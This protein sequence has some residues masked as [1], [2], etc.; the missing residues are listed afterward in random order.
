MPSNSSDLA[1]ALVGG[2]RAF[3][4]YLSDRASGRAEWDLDLEIPLSVVGERHH[5]C[6]RWTAFDNTTGWLAVT[7]DDT[8]SEEFDYAGLARSIVAVVSTVADTF[9][10]SP[11]LRRTRT[12][13]QL[14][15]RNRWVVSVR[16]TKNSLVKGQAEALIGHLRSLCRSIPADPAAEALLGIGAGRVGRWDGSD[17]RIVASKIGEMILHA[18]DGGRCRGTTLLSYVCSDDVV[19]VDVSA[20]GAVE[21]ALPTSVGLSELKTL[22]ASAASIAESAAA[23]RLGESLHGSEV[24]TPDDRTIRSWFEGVLGGSQGV[25]PLHLSEGDRSGWVP[26]RPNGVWLESGEFL[27]EQGA[28]GWYQELVADDMVLLTPKKPRYS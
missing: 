28:E 27:P 8:K 2:E 21:L 20:R 22:L 25:V 9:H 16:L 6:L 7:L 23:F 13:V 24:G 17:V 12:R 14:S 4:F 3:A 15:P 5:A 10:V 18:L 11:G 19:I 1:T 26:S